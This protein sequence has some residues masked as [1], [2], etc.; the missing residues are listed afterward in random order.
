MDDPFHVPQQSRRHKLRYHHHHHN[1]QDD[2][3]I[4]NPQHHPFL[5]PLQILQS[6]SS[7]STSADHPSLMAAASTNLSLSSSS[8]HARAYLPSPVGPFTGY[9]SILGRSR[10]LRPA[11][12]LLE[13]VSR[14]SGIPLD[15]HGRPNNN[16]LEDS[17]TLFNDTDDDLSLRCSNP[18]LV[19]MLHEVY[20]RYKLYCQQMQSA[21]TSFESVAGLGNAAPFLCFAV[22]AMFRHFQCLK[23]A[24]LDQIRVTSKA[25]GNVDSRRDSTPGS[26]SEDKGGP[27]SN[28]LQHPVWRSQRGFPD[29]AVAV[30]RNWLFEHFLHPYPTDSDKQMLAEKTGL[31]RSQVSNWFTN[32]RVRLWKPM[33]EEMHALERKTQCSKAEDTERIVNLSNDHQTSLHSQLSEKDFQTTYSHREEDN[34]QCKRS[35]I[36]AFARAEQGKEQ[37]RRLCNRLPS[38]QVLDIGGSHTGQQ[39]LSHSSA[40]GSNQD[41]TTGLSWS[42]HGQIVPFWL[43]KQ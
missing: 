27:A 14:V 22:R 23:N 9:A 29:K 31:S 36:E 15:K 24:I 25:F 28:F 2:D 17:G 41:N 39:H 13:E 21:V 37:L 19:S 12:D 33:V 42:N 18:N 5:S 1:H 40:M 10:F 16:I 30:L 7:A 20:K 34:S 3:V 35:R 6:T 43:A 4:V 38:N 11:Q 32:A 26:C 8:T